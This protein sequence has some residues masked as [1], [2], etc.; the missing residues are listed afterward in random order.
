MTDPT[1]T[2]HALLRME[3]MG[4]TDHDIAVTLDWPEVCTPASRTRDRHGNR[5]EVRVGENVKQF[6]RDGHAVI[7]DCADPDRPR[8]ITI[9]VRTSD[10]YERPDS[11]ETRP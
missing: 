9:L 3:Q 11:K 7:A 1:F 2:R 5:I 8:V 10:Q 6:R 4:L